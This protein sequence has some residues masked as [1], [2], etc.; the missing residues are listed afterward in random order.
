MYGCSIL[1]TFWLSEHPSPHISLDNRRS[2][3]SQSVS[4]KFCRIILKKISYQL[5][6]SLIGWF[7]DI[8]GLSYAKPILPRCHK[9]NIK[10]VFGYYD[11]TAL[12]QAVI[13]SKRTVTVYVKV[14]LQYLF[15]GFHK[16]VMMLQAL[17]SRIVIIKLWCRKAWHCW[18]HFTYAL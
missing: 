2:T 1:R 5:C 3:V 14:K 10:L 7:E 15:K 12:E 8:F 16:L 18:P 17:L 4:R 11:Q 9:E 6:G 13:R